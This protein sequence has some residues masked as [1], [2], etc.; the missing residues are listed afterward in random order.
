MGSRHVVAKPADLLFLGAQQP[1]LT[2]LWRVSLDKRAVLVR[3]V[4]TMANL[5]C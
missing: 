2:I 1:A 5:P 4:A 3:H